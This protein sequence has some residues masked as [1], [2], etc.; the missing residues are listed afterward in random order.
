MLKKLFLIISLLLIQSVAVAIP[1]L[2]Q[3][4][5]VAQNNSNLLQGRLSLPSDLKPNYSPDVTIKGGNE[6]DYVNYFLQYFAGA[7]LW[8]AAPVA[9]LVIAVGGVRYVI[10]HGEDGQIEGAKN[11]LMWGV[12]GLLVIMFSYA[13]VRI[14]ITLITQQGS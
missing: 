11:T 12:I 2:A 3:N 1:A 5:L 13:A 6:A 8:I 4:S 10:S 9:I 7:L 14:V